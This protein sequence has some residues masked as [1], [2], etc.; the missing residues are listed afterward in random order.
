MDCC[1]STSVSIVDKNSD[2]GVRPTCIQILTLTP[3]NF[4]SWQ[5]GQSQ[6][7]NLQDLNGIIIILRVD[8]KIR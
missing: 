7:P 3:N 6:Y 8:V 4:W 1:V 2:S 5:I